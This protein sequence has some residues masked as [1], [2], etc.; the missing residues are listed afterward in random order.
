M[1]RMSWTF[2]FTYTTQRGQNQL[3]FTSFMTLRKCRLPLT[4]L[5]TS[6]KNEYQ[7]KQPLDAL[8]RP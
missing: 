5:C 8:K 7:T 2:S 6:F 3:T 4:I 1:Y